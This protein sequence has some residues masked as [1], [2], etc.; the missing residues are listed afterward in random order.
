MIILSL[1]ENIAPFR[2][3]C[4]PM[5]DIKN[6]FAKPFID[7]NQASLLEDAEWPISPIFTTATVP[8]CLH[9]HWALWTPF[10]QCKFRARQE[11]KVICFWTE[12]DIL[13]LSL[14]CMQGK[15]ID[16]KCQGSICQSL[17]SQSFNNVHKV[18]DNRLHL[19]YSSLRG[20]G[21]TAVLIYQVQLIFYQG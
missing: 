8:L 21:Y 5:S 20:D 7:Q 15:T 19:S 3:P 10:R 1:V 6:I 11:N 4:N 14:I 17:M 18:H 12:V 9:L 16:Y 2:I 13:L